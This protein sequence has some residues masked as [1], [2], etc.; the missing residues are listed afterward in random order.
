MVTANQDFCVKCDGKIM[1]V[2]GAVPDQE[3]PTK[4]YD[5]YECSSCPHKFKVLRLPIPPFL[6]I[7]CSLS[8]SSFAFSESLMRMSA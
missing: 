2:K 5:Y 6:H 3:D 8:P 7:I 4:F 1:L